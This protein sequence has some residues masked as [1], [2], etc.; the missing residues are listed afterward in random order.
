MARLQRHSVAKLR[1]LTHLAITEPVGVDIQNQ[2]VFGLNFIGRIK[3]FKANIKIYATLS[4]T[5]GSAARG[6]T[7]R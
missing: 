5:V 7:P 3:P 6:Y 4:P 2:Y 1:T